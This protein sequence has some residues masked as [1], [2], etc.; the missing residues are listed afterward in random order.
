MSARWF[1][2]SWTLLRRKEAGA[3]ERSRTP[4][5]LCDAHQI[6]QTC[7]S[8]HPFHALA[9]PS[10]AQ[11][12]AL[13][14]SPEGDAAMAQPPPAYKRAAHPASHPTFRSPLH[15]VVSHSPYS[16]S[17][18]LTNPS[19]RS[20]LS[21]LSQPRI[22]RP[23]LD[24]SFL[25]TLLDL[26]VL[27]PFD[28]SAPIPFRHQCAD[29]PTPPVSVQSPGLTPTPPPPFNTGKGSG[30]STTLPMRVWPYCQASP[31]SVFSESCA[32]L[33]RRDSRIQTHF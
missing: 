23:P 4:V 21:P 11:S 6:L 16:A 30:A 8:T 10:D 32:W 13:G 27:R 24:R 29:R 19:D 25:A 15:S 7:S 12:C 31:A 20:P 33:L 22:P 17:T 2:A 3:P 14:R 1:F 9:T 26:Q 28:N 5:A 18:S